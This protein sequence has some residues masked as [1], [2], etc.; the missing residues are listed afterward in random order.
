MILKSLKINTEKFGSN[1][2]S[3]AD[4]C[5]NLAVIYSNQQKINLAE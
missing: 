4:T 3:V 2:I 1:H 5:I